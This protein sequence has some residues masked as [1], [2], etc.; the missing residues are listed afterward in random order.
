M[1]RI[2][3]FIML[4]CSIAINVYLFLKL[5]EQFIDNSI[6]PYQPEPLNIVSA[7]HNTKPTIK[8]NEQPRSLKINNALQES[9][10]F[11][12]SFLIKSLQNKQQL[13]ELKTYWLSS[14]KTLIATG[15]FIEADKAITAYLE[16]NR[17][18]LD[19]LY[20]QVD[21]YHKQQRVLTAIEYAYNIQYHVFTENQ[22]REV[23][24]HARQMVYQ[25]AD[26]FIQ[27]NQWLELQGFI[28]QLMVIDVENF[29]L[30][31]LYTRAQYHLGEFELA[32]NSIEPLLTAP[33]YT[34]K[35]NALL[36]KIQAALRQ[37]EGIQLTKQG[38][39][40]IVQASVNESFTVALMIDTGA[41]ISL[42]SEQAFAEV[43]QYTQV[44]YVK[45]LTLS[46]AGGLVTA[47]IYQ[48]QSLSIQGYVV[49]DF[50]FAVSPLIGANNDGLLGMNYLRAF[51]FTIDQRHN[52]L[53]LNNK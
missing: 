44:D 23:I 4:L 5:N 20:L 9:D 7:T 32:R 34:V 43:N 52:L 39:H 6:L 21:N 25:Y 47:S 26:V 1:W 18:D 22:K 13:L 30:N 36:T 28:E 45:E 27:N 38:E 41:S 12:A 46:T 16:F 53:I 37:P 48:A 31:W 3:L 14:T 15:Q 17:D 42:L 2:T 51:E 19:F 50:L 10:Y 8:Y 33:N 11:L 40:F 35:A 24:E 29:Q 49:K